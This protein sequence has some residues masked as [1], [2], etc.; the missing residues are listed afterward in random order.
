M[1][2]P[3]RP[4]PTI[5]NCMPVL[6]A[7]RRNRLTSAAHLIRDFAQIVRLSH[8]LVYDIKPAQPLRLVR[9][10][11]ERPIAL[12]QAFHFSARLPLADRTLNRRRERLGQRRFQPTHACAF[13]WVLFSTTARSVSKASA[14]NLTPSSVSLS[15]TSFIEMPALARSS[16]VFCAPGISSVK[17]SRTRP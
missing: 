3:M 14:N 5:P 1:L 9:A 2:E 17:L 8:L 15:V 11:L 4:R 7:L 16:M 10:G 13:R 6:L 12:P